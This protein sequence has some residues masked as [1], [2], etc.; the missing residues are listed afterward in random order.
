LFGQIFVVT[1][2]TNVWSCQGAQKIKS[3]LIL[4]LNNFTGQSQSSLGVSQISSVPVPPCL[5]CLLLLSPLSPSFPTVS[6]KNRQCF[7][8]LPLSA[9]LYLFFL[10]LSL[11]LKPMSRVSLSILLHLSATGAIMC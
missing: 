11:Y 5:P 1:L 6:L 3:K 2:K 4:I 8:F 9:Q 7:V 10:D